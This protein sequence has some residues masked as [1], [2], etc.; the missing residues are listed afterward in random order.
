MGQYGNDRIPQ[1]M[2]QQG[3]VFTTSDRPVYG[4]I[5]GAS[6]VYNVPIAPSALANQNVTWETATSKDIGFDWGIL[7]GKLSG[8]FDYFK[9][10]TENILML[11]SAS[12]PWSFGADV[13]MQNIGIVDNWGFETAVRLNTK[14][15][16]VNISFEPNIT[17]ANS[18]VIEMAEAS[19]VPEGLRQT[20]KPFDQRFGYVAQGL[21]QTTDFNADGTL[22][23][24]IVSQYP[25][26]AGDIKYK[27]ISGPNGVPDQYIDYY[28]RTDIGSSRLPKYIYGLNLGLMYKNFDLTASFQGAFGYDAYRWFNAFDLTS[29]ASAVITDSW[30]PGNENARFPRTYIGQSDDNSQTSS[31]WLV[32]GA[33]LKL[34]NIVLAYTMP[35][36][37][38]LQKIGISN[39]RFSISGNNLFTISKMTEYDP[40]SPDMD[41]TTGHYYFQWKSVSGGLSVTF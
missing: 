28:D 23:N 34:R 33:Y 20:G 37:T 35:K 36:M 8:E 11:P 30:R 21:Y 4:T 1:Y 31:Y 38:A 6:P 41:S 10:R 27:D 40:E 14:A 24:G 19:N 5:T 26:Q 15:G 32:P 3:Y 22:V 12:V 7:G 29:N 9:K 13:P 16:P 17:Y 25:I 39:L 2:Y 18:K